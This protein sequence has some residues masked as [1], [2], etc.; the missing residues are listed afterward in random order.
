MSNTDSRVAEQ[1]EPTSFASE[2]ASCDGPGVQ[3]N[4][5][6]QVSSTRPK[7]HLQ[8]SCNLDHFITTIASKARHDHGVVFVGCKLHEGK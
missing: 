4:A 8:V 1:L 2:N 3:S 6:L 5:Q 7:G